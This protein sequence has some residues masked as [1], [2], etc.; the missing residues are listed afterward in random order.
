MSKVVTRPQWT[1]VPAS[2]AD[3]SERAKNVSHLLGTPLQRTQEWLARL[4][5]HQ[6]LH[7]LQAQL[8]R[9]ASDPSSHV[10]GPY[11]DQM[12]LAIASMTNP[13]GAAAIRNSGVSIPNGHEREEH[14][15]HA[16]AE[17]VGVA[18]HRE[19]VIKHRDISNIELFGPIEF[20][21]PAFARVRD[22]WRVIE[23][24]LVEPADARPEDYATLVERQSG[25]LMLELTNLG[26]AVVDAVQHLRLDLDHRVVFDK[27]NDEEARAEAHAIRESAFQKTMQIAVSFPHN[28][29]AQGFLVYPLVERGRAREATQIAKQ[30]MKMLDQLHDGQLRLAMPGNHGCGTR[31]DNYAV[32]HILASALDA[33]EAASEKGL[34]RTWRATYNRTQKNEPIP[35]MTVEEEA[36]LAYAESQMRHH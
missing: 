5:G 14:L 1:F 8:K 19:M 30:A 7:A 4:Y 9:A 26:M 10:P 3:F 23:G 11:V 31:V 21:R 13:E 12:Q 6:H 16:T 35:K 34:A 32:R 2:S 17:L 29:W 24:L 27:A 36:L 15:L 18:S 20:H 22:K 28:P 25:R 33:A